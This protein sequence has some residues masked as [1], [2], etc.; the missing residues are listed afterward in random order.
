MDH[1]SANNPPTR[2]AYSLAIVANAR[3]QVLGDFAQQAED[4]GYEAIWRPEGLGYDP[5]I[6]C[7]LW[8]ART[9]HISLGTGIASAFGRAPIVLAQ[10]AATLVELSDG[11]FRLGLG[12]GTL[13]SRSAD[14]AP[15]SRRDEMSRIIRQVRVLLSGGEIGPGLRLETFAPAPIYLAALGP[16]MMQLSGAVADGV[17][18]NWVTPEAISSSRLRIKEGARLVGRDIATIQV[19]AYVRVAVGPWD[20]VC[21]SL[22]SEVATFAQLPVYA[23]HFG[24]LSIDPQRVTD[25]QIRNLVVWGRDRA[26]VRAGLDRFKEAGLDEVIVRPVVVE[27]SWWP[28]VEAAGVR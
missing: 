3:L 14:V 9:R 22:R 28:A 17:I 21:E 13:T 10:T 27:G 25:E 15:S 18:L 24:T 6:V 12:L 8:A 16:V 19:A 26:E 1:P 20:S 2:P 11:R 23:R 4:L 5:F 7:A